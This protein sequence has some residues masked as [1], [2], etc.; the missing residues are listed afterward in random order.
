MMLAFVNS[1]AGGPIL[2]PGDLLAWLL[3][4]LIAG[5]F[6]S[7]VI[8]GRGYGCIGNIIVG[9]VGG[10]IGGYLAGLLHIQGVYHFWG[11]VLIAFI[12]ACVLVAVLQLFSGGRSSS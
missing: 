4:G 9:L 11:S 1:I 3:V 8:R 2:F 12:G 5:F 10:G 7:A 6:A